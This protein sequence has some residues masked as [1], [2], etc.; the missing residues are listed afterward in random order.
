M[1]TAADIL[2]Q[3]LYDAGCRHAFG[4]PGGEVLTVM[5][6][7]SDAGLDFTL[8]KH[9]NSAGFMA[10]GSYHAS[11]APGVLIATL[12]PGVANAVNVIAN[13]E[14]DRVPLIF[15]T[16]C[17]D[18]ATAAG[19]TH[20][21]FDHRALLDPIT[22][23][24]FTLTDGAV[25]TIVAK[26]L[27]IAMEGRPG[28]VHIDVPMSVAGADQPEPRKIV[29]VHYAP[30]APAPGPDLEKACDLFASAERP[31]LLAGLEVL[32]QGGEE[33]VADFAREH[34]IPVITTYK[35]KGIL[36]EGDP[37][38]LGGA[39]LS[40]LADEHLLPLVAQADLILLA[41][42]DP[43]EM[44][45]NWCRPWD[46]EK[47]P[48][49]EVTAA[50]NHHG[51]HDASVTFVG[52]IVS[53]LQA[54]GGH[55]GASKAEHWSGGEAAAV[56]ESLRA[57]FRTNED[58]GPGA[59]IEEVRRLLPADGVATADSGAHRILLS[60][61]WDCPQP[62]GLLQSSGLCTMGCALPIA[63]GF[64]L[65]AP[66]RPVVAFTGDAGLEMILGELTTLRDLKL[67]LVVVVFVDRSLALIELKQRGQG[68]RN[69]AVDFGGTDFPALAEAL[70]GRG[71]A[72]D[73]RAD[74]A[75]AV[76]S[77]LAS[78]EGFTLI[79]AEIGERAYDGRF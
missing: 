50:P 43:I 27:T 69:L 46:P 12:G 54:I 21:V 25:E 61:L 75:V 73:N 36:P 16:G 39:G 20:Q 34:R 37:L 48:V 72:V 14:Q 55:S 15:L 49:I 41:G 67:P 76:E 79:A 28:P 17:V 70:G 23:A 35:A 78:K 19:Y 5:H 68:L 11:G 3:A 8:T 32:A 64:K 65:A 26:A 62:R 9:E 22:K 59:A 42:Y 74:M 56:R 51:M 33:G 2:A 53:G 10:E 6:A 52:H 18:E 44:R 30:A 63:M 58:W 31:L 77:G 1:T 24:S 29:P 47:V 60:Q 57:A 38:S 40:P 7:L 4:I 13:A 71:I 66:E 45:Q